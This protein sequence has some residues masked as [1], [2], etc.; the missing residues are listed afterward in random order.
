[1]DQINPKISVI[2]P[3]YNSSQFLRAAIESIL[4]QTMSDYEFIIINDGSNDES[5]EIISEY[6]R[7][8]ARIC[9]INNK[10]NSGLID[11]LNQGISV[12]TGD[13][14]ARMDADDI[15][16]PQRFKVQSQFLDTHPEVGVVGS[17][18]HFIDSSGRRISNFINN[19]RLPQ[20]T[21]QIKWSLCFSCCLIHPTI[22]M[23]QELVKKVGGYNKQAK[24]AEDY[25][26]WERMSVITNYY[27][28]SQKYLL[29][30]KH[31][32]NVTVLHMDTTLGNSQKISQKLL[33]NYLGYEVTN[34]EI[35]IFWNQEPSNNPTA[36]QIINIFE[37]L[38]KV[39]ITDNH[40]FQDDAIFIKNDITKRI[41][42]FLFQEHYHLLD[43]KVLLSYAC[44][45][46]FINALFN[47]ILI[48][49]R[50]FFRLIKITITENF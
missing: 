15:S 45:S 42:E 8:D 3:V 12:S 6:E 28:L 11:V 50:Q 39:F 40:L 13:Y 46:N 22:M 47:Y 16:L 10:E 5:V 31:E 24:H 37:N 2:M 34:D 26:L 18:V 19:P 21:N 32:K 36:P 9:F 43:Q 38:L 30:R 20:T 1:M 49:S 29:L 27:N 7:K 17:N 23:R 4:N 35:A 33:S 41:I 14:I 44:R 48:K 25:D